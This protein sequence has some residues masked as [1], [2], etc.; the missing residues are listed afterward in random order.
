MAPSRARGDD[1]VTPT[2]PRDPADWAAVN[3][4]FHKAI[5]LPPGERAAFIDRECAGR[6]DLRAEALS[7]LASHDRADTFLESGAANANAPRAAG[8]VDPLVGRRVGHYEI[9]GVLG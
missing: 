8:S 9:E 7:L 4:V 1:D 5:D 2:G 3:A 6:P